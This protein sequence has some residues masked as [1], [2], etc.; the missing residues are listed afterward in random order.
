MPRKV[1]KLPPGPPSV[2]DTILTTQIAGQ[3]KAGK[4]LCAAER[5]LKAPLYRVTGLLKGWE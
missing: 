5:A 1:P 3:V 4:A 2:A